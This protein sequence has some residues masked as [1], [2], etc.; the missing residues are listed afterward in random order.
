ME[1]EGILNVS[2]KTGLYKVIS[3]AKSTVAVESLEDG[4]YLKRSL[5]TCR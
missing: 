4:K 1:L 5:E 2:G 3:Q